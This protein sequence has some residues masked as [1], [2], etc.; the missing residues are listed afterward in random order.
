MDKLISD[1]KSSGRV[2]NWGSIE[3]GEAL[4]RQRTLAQEVVS[5]GPQTLVLCEHPTVITLGRTYQEKNLFLSREALASRGIQVV[6]ID[7]GGDVTLHAPGQLVAY[8][9]IDLKRSHL[10]LRQF[11]QNLEQVAVD[12]LGSF[13]IVAQGDDNRRGV[14]VHG[15]KIASIGI[16]VSRWVTY[17]GIALNI[18]T[19]L[20]NFKLIRPCG[21]D[22]RMTSLEELTGREIGVDDAKQD[23]TEHFLRVFRWDKF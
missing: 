12:F 23:F 13:A 3:Y 22:V 5:G 2:V 16:S 20:E 18:S 8:P 17:H 9:I 15:R 6:A 10:G 4:K 11:L 14:W 7:R 1:Q 19:D 21:L